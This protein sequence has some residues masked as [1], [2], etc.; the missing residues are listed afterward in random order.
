MGSGVG[1][2]IGRC[3]HGVVVTHVFFAGAIEGIFFLPA[4]FEKEIEASDLAQVNLIKSRTNF[5][6][7]LSI[8]P[9]QENTSLK[10]RGR[11]VSLRSGSVQCDTVYLAM[12]FLRW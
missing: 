6:P 8:L 9:L 3:S 2:I 4:K 1:M 11:S 12:L 7:S 10:S 5:L